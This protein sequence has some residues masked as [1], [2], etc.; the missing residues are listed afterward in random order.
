MYIFV[1]QHDNSKA[2]KEEIFCM[3]GNTRS[4]LMRLVYHLRLRLHSNFLFFETFLNRQT[5]LK[6][7]FSASSLNTPL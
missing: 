2:I 1:Y 5:K 4:K 6:S 7:M 3:L